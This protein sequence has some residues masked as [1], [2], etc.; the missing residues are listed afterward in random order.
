MTRQADA[1]DSPRRIVREAVIQAVA[2]VAS[3]AGDRFARY[4]DRFMPAV[5]AVIRQW[6]HERQEVEEEADE[7]IWNRAIECASFICFAVPEK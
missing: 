5:M 2:S 6:E 4:Y 3:T 7:E 1:V